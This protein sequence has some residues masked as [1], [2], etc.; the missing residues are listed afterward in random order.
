MVK[1]AVS[2][3]CPGLANYKESIFLLQCNLTHLSKGF[4]PTKMGFNKVNYKLIDWGAK[5][6]NLCQ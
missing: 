3:K 4:Q 6:Y 1:A 2:A 5:Q